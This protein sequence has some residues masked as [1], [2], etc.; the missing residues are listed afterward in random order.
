MANELLSQIPENLSLLQ[1]TKFTF[2]IPQLPFLKY[3]CQTV[4]LPG[5]STN[6]IV[7]TTLFN[8]TYKFGSKVNFDPLTITSLV[9]EDIR[10][11]EE[12]YQWM[13]YLANPVQFGQ[14][15]N[16]FPS[17][18]YDAILTLNTN[19]N[20]PNL[21]IKFKNCFPTSVGS[22]QFATTDN[23]DVVPVLDISFRYDYFEIDRV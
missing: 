3:F 14:F 10:V 23:A 4:Q 8:D 20:N 7:Q 18:F 11:W 13:V 9:D 6:E 22:I 19:A 17:K 15:K 12:T 16:K 5:I 1:T 2:V 21:R